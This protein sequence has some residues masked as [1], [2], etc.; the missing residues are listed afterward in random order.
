VVVSDVNN[1]IKCFETKMQYL[2]KIAI[3][4]LAKYIMHQHEGG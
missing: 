3:S 2:K 1:T 4:L